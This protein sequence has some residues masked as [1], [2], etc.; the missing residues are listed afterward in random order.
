MNS[1]DEALLL[2]YARRPTVAALFLGAREVCKVFRGV[3][4]RRPLRSN[5]SS[6][7]ANLI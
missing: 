1:G 4:L 2:G 6:P 7:D 3:R 5:A